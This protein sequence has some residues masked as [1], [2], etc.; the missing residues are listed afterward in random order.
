MFK[1]FFDAVPRDE[2][3]AVVYEAQIRDNQIDNLRRKYVYMLAAA[4]DD[5]VVWN[6]PS[7]YEAHCA[8]RKK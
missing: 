2:K 7:L 1:Q 4:M 3:L 8:K 5:S 6:G